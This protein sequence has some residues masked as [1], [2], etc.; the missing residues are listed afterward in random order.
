MGYYFITSDFKDDIK[1]QV[2]NNEYK[3]L[4]KF[5][6]NILFEYLIDIIDLIAIKFNFDTSAESKNTYIYQFKQ[7]NYQDIKGLLNLLLPFI[8][9]GAD[10]S[11][12]RS[13]N[14]LYINKQNNLPV[15]INK[16]EPKYKFTNIQY[17]RC[18]RH[19]SKPMSKP[20]SEPMEKNNS[21]EIEFN[22]KHLED[23]YKLLKETI[24][25]I[26]NKLYVNWV[27]ILPMPNDKEY[28]Q[29]TILYKNTDININNNGLYIGDIYNTLAHY[30]YEHILDIKWLIY[31]V[32]IDNNIVS[33]TDLLK[34]LLP[35]DTIIN[36]IIWNNLV[37]HEQEE[38]NKKWQYLLANIDMN[39]NNNYN[40]N[41]QLIKAMTIFFDLKYSQSEEV[42][43]AGYSR[44][45]LNLDPEDDEVQL[46]RMV[47][48]DKNIFDSAKT[49]SGYM[50]YNYLIF[51]FERFKTSWYGNNI[52]NNNNK[53]I[54]QKISF[55]NIYNYAKSLTTY[56]VDNKLLKYP[57]YWSMLNDEDRT[58]IL[59]RLDTNNNSSWFNISGYLRH[60]KLNINSSTIHDIVRDNLKD[61]IFSCMT[62]NGLLSEFKP[63][64]I[65]TDESLIPTTYNEQNIYFKDRMKKHHDA[66]I[67]IW[68]KSYYYLTNKLY[69]SQYTNYEKNNTSY[70][71]NYL[72]TISE[73][74]NMGGWFVTY[75]MNW[76]SQISF[77]HKYLNNRV[78]YVTGSTGVGKST[79]IPKLL[80]YAM[81][82]IDC[83]IDGKIVATVPRIPVA[84]ENAKTISTQLGVPILEYNSSLKS[85]IP[86]SN[87]NVQYQYRDK[88]HTKIVSGLMLKIVTDGLL[89]QEILKYPLLKKTTNNKY[90][91][92]NQNI[93]D[94]VIVDEAH[95]HNK[96]MDYIL[97]LMK[98][99]LYY[100]NN[101]KL[102]IISATM[103]DDEP[104]Y[105]R[106]YRDI[107][108][109]RIF[110]FSNFIISNNIDRINVDRRLHISPP[111]GTTRHK[112]ED[113]YKPEMSENPEQLVLEVA[114]KTNNGDILFFR[115]GIKEIMK[116]IEI[117]N[118][119]L[120]PNFIA[121]PFY[122]ELS[123]DRRSI[124]SSISDDNKKKITDSRDSII[125]NNDNDNNKKVAEGT[126]T[127]VVIVATNLA[128][129]SL[130][131]NTLK[132]VV[133]SGTEKSAIY[134]YKSRDS[135]IILSNISESSRMQRR[136]RVGR[137]APGTVYY[138][139]SK[140]SRQG[141]KKPFNIAISNIYEDL[142]SMLSNNY[143][144]GKTIFNSKNDPNTN[145]INLS[146][147]HLN[148][149]YPD[150]YDILIK[151]QYYYEK[152][153]ISYYGD[154]NC[155]DYVNFTPPHK[156]YFNNNNNGY[157]KSTLEDE[158]GTFYIVHPDELLIERNINGNIVNL[159][160]NT[161][162][163]TNYGI[164]L[165]DQKI[166][167]YK[168]RSFWDILFEKL[169]L[170]SKNNNIIKTEFG[171]NIMYVKSKLIEISI[172]DIV[173]YIYSGPYGV[174]GDILKIFAMVNTTSGNIASLSYMDNNYQ[175]KIDKLINRYGNC[176]SDSDGLI[177]LANDIID[178]FVSLK[179]ISI[180]TNIEKILDENEIID[181]KQKYIKGKR[182]NNYN[183]IA[184]LD[185]T[186]IDKLI[187]LDH[188]N[189]LEYTN[190]LSNKERE[191]FLKNDLNIS[192]VDSKLN[193]H[194]KTIMDW[195]RNN[196]FE[197][198]TIIS[199]IKNYTRISNDFIK[200]NSDF[201]LFNNII[202]IDKKSTNTE[203][204][205][206]A[207]LH[208]NGYKIAKKI[209]GTNLYVQLINPSPNNVYEIG[210]IT[211]RAHI[212][213]TLV[214]N[215]CLGDYIMYLK[216]NIE[217]NQLLLIHNVTPQLIQSITPYVYS[218]ELF[219]KENY[220]TNKHTD[221]IT[222]LTSQFDLNITDDLN[223]SL[224]TQNIVKDYVLTIKN[225]KKDM[226][227][228]FNQLTYKKIMSLDP[229]IEYKYAI[230]QYIKK[231]IDIKY[232]RIPNVID[233]NNVNNLV[234]LV[235]GYM[236]N[237][238]N[239][240]ILLNSMI[241]YYNNL[242]VDHIMNKIY[243][244]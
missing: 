31:D 41:K 45:N 176:V 170:Y 127:R 21:K 130:T 209:G 65:M 68:N 225:I 62:F 128:E 192:I 3:N 51:A 232:N 165:E 162:T 112:I 59:N 223:K 197:Y 224:L 52:L 104:T 124:V 60:V 32:N 102:I 239:N 172:D 126:Y 145:N 19:V 159:S 12:I 203:N 155:Y 72:D 29:Q 229:D 35:L 216:Q 196:Y 210:R 161:N 36:N 194:K 179:I 123:S 164:K 199:F 81:K 156:L 79:Q 173:S 4:N 107:N 150:N 206:C 105:R 190:K 215:S 220:T 227:N 70:K 180:Q 233:K 50:I 158:T 116:S 217:F 100:N 198:K 183:D 205:T 90:N 129:A 143:V 24:H 175:Y 30:L 177:K 83:K 108:D 46:S 78:I 244:K 182:T 89:L 228:N 18:T 5:E 151:E 241:K 34:T 11:E 242:Y 132:Y 236:H 40:A 191:Q 74:R 82:M 171:N 38:F 142:M 97:T 25:Q 84:I 94:T 201:E 23:N 139:Y 204:I 110:P 2:I 157:S 56:V 131:I 238:N 109:N 243:R 193:E 166:V 26:S 106:F 185:N 163:N 33:F 168:I 148:L 115:P 181:I 28:Y 22:I 135:A 7:N 114:N 103:D 221:A 144:D 80:L 160:T 77:F 42:E 87:Y 39:T 47:K 49:I 153:F 27:D 200:Y 125:N 95:E 167:S 140:D 133:D 101:I 1:N 85:T 48:Y 111:G 146:P 136:G 152:Q 117:L 149:L 211:K 113:V 118:T 202:K 71:Q 226:L 53:D 235:G 208:G 13:L 231:Q 55:K 57:R 195:C 219:S 20:M 138:L 222:Y 120:P 63:N 88:K 67:N 188:N 98:Y 240:N 9:D 169:C 154:P 14:D 6:Q 43:L 16:T 76:V 213:N 134:D 69:N 186:L 93:Y 207:L 44:L 234:N 75:A 184:N 189:N 122:S 10:K 174:T 17:G 230:E 66:N 54:K 86:S 37:E 137:V 96:N 214:K 218:P 61:I 15:D 121:L 92:Y 212:K 64:K 119:K 99:A 91:K 237:N 187:M 73:N 8:K 147:D 58:T 178:K 141:T